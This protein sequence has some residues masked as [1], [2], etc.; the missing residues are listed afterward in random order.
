MFGNTDPNTPEGG[1][2]QVLCAVF[3]TFGK[4]PDGDSEL[5]ITLSVLTRDGQTH[6][7]VVDMRP[8]FATEDA[9]LRHWLLIDEVWEIPEP[10]GTGGGGFTPDVEDW[11]DVEE[12]IPIGPRY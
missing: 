5:H 3:N 8:I 4:V 6:Q 2:E 9:R 12:T 7:K 11:D 10:I 1:N